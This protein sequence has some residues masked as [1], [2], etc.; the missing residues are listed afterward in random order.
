MWLIDTS[1]LRLKFF[2]T[3]KGL[4]Y[5]ILS[6]T[7]GDEEVSFEEM[8]ARRVWG[9]RK[10]GW[11]KILETCRIARGTFKLEYAW[12]DTCCINKASSAE[13]SEAINSM[14]SWYKAAAV[15]LVY[16]KDFTL[17]WKVKLRSPEFW[18]S[19]GACRWFSRGWTLQEL[20]APSELV[21]YDSNWAKFGTKREFIRGL[22]AI[23]KIEEGVLRN[24]DFLAAAH[25]GKKMS[26]AAFR[27]TTR[28]ED[29]AYCLLGIFDINMP[30]LYGEGAKAFLRLQEE[31]ARSRNDMTLFAW[32]QD[33]EQDENQEE[34]PDDDGDED[35]DDDGDEASDDDGDEGS[36]QDW[37]ESSEVYGD[38]CSEED[39]DEDP[40]ESGDEQQDERQDE[41]QDD[42]SQLR[43]IFA[44]SPAE[45]RNCNK[46]RVPDEPFQQDVEFS[47]TNRGLRIDRNLISSPLVGLTL[48]LDC[49]ECS[50]R[51]DG[52]AK[53]IH[54]YLEKVGSVYVRAYPRMFHY[55]P[56]RP[57]RQ[58]APSGQSAVYIATIMPRSLAKNMSTYITVNIVYAQSLWDRV[59]TDNISTP[60]KLSKS[61]ISQQGVGIITP[62]SFRSHR[63]DLKSVPRVKHYSLRQDMYDV[64]LYYSQGLQTA[65]HCHIISVRPGG[66]T[67]VARIAL[68]CGLAR[69]NT[70]DL[71]TR[72]VQFPWAALLFEGDLSQLHG[73]PVSDPE[74]FSNSSERGLSPEKMRTFH[75]YIFENYSDEA[76]ALRI[77]D[78]PT[79]VCIKDRNLAFEVLHE[80]KVRAVMGLHLNYEFCLVV[81]CSTLR[82]SISAEPSPYSQKPSSHPELQYPTSSDPPPLTFPVRSLS[83]RIPVHELSSLPL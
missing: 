61:D 39:G 68:V 73:H 33:K 38:E 6:H 24:A 34:D 15:C 22:S 31:I 49:L 48:C 47:L 16:L 52:K 23:T 65:R 69:L 74:L 70:K 11:E 80:V 81:S 8:N 18:S 3:S 9:I 57:P 7:W 30:L 53:W 36:E 58:T 78:M 2:P 83:R 82:R 55:T 35:P 64:D 79:S 32:E 40:E 59:H 56:S 77:K 62:E 4:K 72:N 19:L 41:Q 54:L 10:K 21:F 28:I 26:W 44:A 14:F 5:A 1:T 60:H 71:N 27:E 63:G 29:I 75:D 13:L 46:L 76:G 43:G 25:V 66:T 12:V 37:G 51:T 17:D 50:P 20:I 45:F 42:G 67:Q